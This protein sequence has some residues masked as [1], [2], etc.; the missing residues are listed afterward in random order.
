MILSLVLG[1][2][3]TVS[4]AQGAEIRGTVQ[5]VDVTSGIVY[6]TDGRAVRVDPG[7]RLYAGGREVRLADIQPGWTFVSSNA[8]AAPGAVA[9]PGAVPPGTV[10]TQPATPSVAQSTASSAAMAAPGLARVDATGVVASVDPRSGTI[11]LQDG[12]VVRMS[13]GTTLWQP[14]TIGS[15]APGASLF[16]RNAEPLDFRP[17]AAPQNRSYQMGTVSSVDASNARVVLSD[18]TIVHMSPGSRIMFN[19]QPLAITALHPGDEI[20]VAVP[21][22]TVTPGASGVSALPRQTA[23]MMETDY[24]YVVRRPQSP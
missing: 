3:V 24:L 14:V 10:V 4:D 8:A 13:S 17:A 12:R 19:G 21:V 20:A 23:G 7:T 1:G 16:V 15:I 18:G 11:T 6:L 2:L 22:T 5:R 9:T